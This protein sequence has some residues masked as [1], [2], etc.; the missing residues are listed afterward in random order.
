MEL[1]KKM[2]VQ[3]VKLTGPEETRVH[4][5]GQHKAYGPKVTEN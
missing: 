3:Y 5:R 2:L 4:C 1:K